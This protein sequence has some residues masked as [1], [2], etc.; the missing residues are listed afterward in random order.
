MRD[1]LARQQRRRGQR[2]SEV[3][4]LLTCVIYLILITLFTT[5]A[6]GEYNNDKRIQTMS[7]LRLARIQRHVDKINKTPVITIHVSKNSFI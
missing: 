3:L 4:T 1:Y 7:S 2:M 6:N 5:A